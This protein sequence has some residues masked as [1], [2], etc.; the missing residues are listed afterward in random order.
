MSDLGSETTG[1]HRPM[2]VVVGVDGS[3]TSRVAVDWAARDAVLR[4][5]PL[6]LLHVMPTATM[7][8]WLDV[9]V[10]DDFW[11]ERD[12]RA[13]QVIADARGWVADAISATPPI[14]VRHQ[15]AMAPAVPTM[16]D[17]SRDADLFVVGCRGLGGVGGL[18]LGSVSSGLVHHA[19]C[20]VAVIHDEDPLMDPSHAP[21]VVGIDGSEASDLAVSVA[22]GEASRRGVDLVAVHV[23]SDH[24]DD[25]VDGFGGDLGEWA[26]ETLAERLAGWAEHHPEVV[27]HRVVEQD[28]P[29][30][31]L[32]DHSDKA[33][34]LVVGSHGRGG[35]SRLI[36]GSVSSA[37]AHRARVPVI[38]A[39]RS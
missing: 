30:R 36:L 19:H 35:A 34:L 25:L 14:D 31:R 23:W 33:Q 32:L 22:F 1:V 27:V 20:P 29:A 38:V 26:D 17:L 5:A 28:H 12:R 37:V 6:T 24:T 3:P 8:T 9:P 15:L 21:V 10:T 2:G 7:A 11:A 4:A 13:E 18:L 16:V 39:R